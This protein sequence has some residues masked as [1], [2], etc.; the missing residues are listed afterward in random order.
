MSATMSMGTSPLCR[1]RMVRGVCANLAE[2]AN[3]PRW[4]P[5][6]AFIILG[7]ANFVLALVVYFGLAWML[8]ETTRPRFT[9]TAWSAR[10]AEMP[11][12]PRPDLYG[13]KERLAS[14]DARLA[15]LEAA[16]VNSE[17]D[18]RRAFR[19]LERQR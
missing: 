10:P 18:L 7:I 1:D 5:R 2:R 8:G 12:R 19:D 3:V 17:A 15:D 11:P 13:L 16:T 4:L 14:L 9:A 6:V